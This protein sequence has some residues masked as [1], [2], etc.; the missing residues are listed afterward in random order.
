MYKIYGS[1]SRDLE[2][3]WFTHQYGDG[4]ELWRELAAKW[5]NG[6]DNGVDQH[7]AAIIRFM[8][9][10]LVPNFICTPHQYLFEKAPDYREFIQSENLSENYK[11]RQINEI[12][13]FID[14]I[15]THEFSEPNDNGALIPLVCN[16]VAKER[17][18]V[19]Y[20]ETVYSPLPYTYIQE[21]RK[22]LCPKE[23]GNFSDWT[24]A[25][26]QTGNKREN[27]YNNGRLG[28]WFYVDE[29]LIDKNDPDCVW[30]AVEIDKPKKIRINGY[31]QLF[32]PGSKIYQLWSPVRAVVLWL[33]LHLPLRTYQV[34]ML[35]SGEADTWR[36]EN[37]QWVSNQK[38]KFSL[39]SKKQ[40]WQKG[41]FRRIR[42]PEIGDIMTGLYINTNK[43]ADRN[44]ETI[45][46]GYVIPWEHRLVLYWMEKLRN[47]QEKYNP[48]C[49]PTSIHSLDL[50][51]FG[52]TKTEV[53]R[54]A[55]GDICFLFRNAAEPNPSN[56]TK[57]MGAV[58][59]LRHCTPYVSVMIAVRANEKRAVLW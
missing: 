15:I 4:W 1:K 12:S 25:I 34:R 28:D 52:S 11:V 39:G 55:I 21:L 22:I 38:N 48:I 2:F 9:N 59:L 8:E 31:T 13:T 51:H 53:Q 27:G 56:R 24:W 26:N 17:A 45:D 33:K 46:R 19:R 7:R 30:R 32:N 43:T 14:W 36:F 41:V 54:E 37:N 49:K 47:W 18:F 42:V 35:D 58:L 16:P 3:R 6:F 44:K 57:P 20:G 50:K 23:N 5:I 29:S 10:Y 40:P